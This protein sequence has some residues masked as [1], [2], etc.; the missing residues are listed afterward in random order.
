M[1]NS[2]DGPAGSRLRLWQGQ[3]HDHGWVIKRIKNRSLRLAR[4]KI[5]I[6]FSKVCQRSGLD[7]GLRLLLCFFVRDFDVLCS[8]SLSV[9]G[10]NENAAGWKKYRLKNLQL[11]L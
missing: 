1:L 11:V 5:G 2:T 3:G 4:A 7:E 9:V 10:L 6:V 8:L